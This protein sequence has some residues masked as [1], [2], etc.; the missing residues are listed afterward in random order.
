LAITQ[1]PPF[2][3]EEARLASSSSGGGAA[4]CHL[5]SQLATGGL[6]S[7]KKDSEKQARERSMEFSIG[8]LEIG[9]WVVTK[10][11]YVH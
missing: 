6:Y 11:L 1:K 10:V 5:Q 7:K 4:R 9:D 3:E 8:I 2:R